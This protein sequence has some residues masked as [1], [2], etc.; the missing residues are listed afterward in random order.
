MKQQEEKLKNQPHLI[1][2]Q[3]TRYLEIHL[4]KEVKDL[5]SENKTLMKE[6]EEGTKKWKDR[7]TWV[8]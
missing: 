7:G 4:T 3:T 2:P 1:A 6:T 8:A 5:D